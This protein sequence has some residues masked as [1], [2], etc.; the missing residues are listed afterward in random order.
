LVDHRLPD[1]RFNVGVRC[2]V[3]EET[4]VLVEPNGSPAPTRTSPAALMT[5][6]K[7]RA[8]DHDRA[9]ETGVRPVRCLL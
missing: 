6:L 5:K 1:V 8:S 4:G 2:E 3:V 7:M 9:Y